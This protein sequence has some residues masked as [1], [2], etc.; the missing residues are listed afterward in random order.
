MPKLCVEDLEIDYRSE[1]GALL[2]KVSLIKERVHD[3]IVVD[4]DKNKPII[5][6]DIFEKIKQK[7]LDR[8]K[9]NM[10]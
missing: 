5:H 3:I 2:D 7:Y 9:N 4:V 10:I 8:I 1:E 6:K